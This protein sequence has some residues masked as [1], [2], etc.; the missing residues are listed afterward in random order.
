[1]E[2]KI[3]A[4]KQ[5]R[6]MRELRGD[7]PPEPTIR[8]KKRKITYLQRLAEIECTDEKKEGFQTMLKEFND[9]EEKRGEALE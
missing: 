2:F 9:D 1:M 8:K 4:M 3:N 7:P 6:L 5:K